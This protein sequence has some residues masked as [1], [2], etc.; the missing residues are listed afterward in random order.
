MKALKITAAALMM[1]AAALTARVEAKAPEQ[2]NAAQA[3]ADFRPTEEN[4]II[5][6]A[7]A[8]LNLDN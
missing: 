1:A 5:A 6:I 7:N 3:E 2:R 4:D 8:L